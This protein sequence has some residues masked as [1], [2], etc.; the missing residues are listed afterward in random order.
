MSLKE[1]FILK[2]SVGGI[3]GV[4]V[5]VGIAMLCG[6]DPVSDRVPLIVQLFLYAMMGVVGNGGSIVY[7]FES[8]GITKM[9]LVHYSCTIAYFIVMGLIL[10]FGPPSVY[11]IMIGIM[12]VVYFLIWV[13]SYISGKREVKRMNEELKSFKNRSEE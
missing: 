1:K 6:D 7:S 10:D 11:L 9:T 2:A 8:W 13:L 12:T 4:F 5:G 3:L